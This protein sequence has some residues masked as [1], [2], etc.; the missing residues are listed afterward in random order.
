MSPTY[1]IGLLSGTSVD[2]IDA[3]LVHWGKDDSFNIVCTYSL[4][5]PQEI[6][7]QVFKLA[8]SGYHEIEQIRYLDY[9]FAKL[10]G[11]SALELCNK[12]NVDTNSILAIG[13]HGQTIRHYPPNNKPKPSLGFSLQIGDPNTIAEITQITTVADFRRRD[14]AAGGHGAPLAPAFHNIAFRSAD[15]DRIILNTGGIANITYLPKNAQTLGFDTGPSNGLMDS[16]CQLHLKQPYDTNGQW[17]AKGNIDEGLLKQLLTHPYFSL[18]HPKSTG[19]ETFNLS[20]LEEQLAIYQQELKTVDIQ[21]TLLAL[22]IES[23]AIEIEKISVPS[24]CELYICGG[25]AH[26]TH[27]CESLKERLKPKLLASTDLLGLNPDWVEATLFAWLAKQTMQG[28]AGNLPAVTGAKKEV[29]LGGIYL[30][31]S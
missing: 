7:E 1:T 6:K 21:A 18:P 17:A 24:H 4:S 23:I 12:A 20:W 31:N 5:I 3:A 11:Q 8:I 26:K 13:S 25:G 15:S 19:R 27:F 16:W 9:E 29:I 14:I 28:K 10:F 30:A 2:A 22:S